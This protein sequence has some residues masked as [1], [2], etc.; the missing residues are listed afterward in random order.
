MLTGSVALSFSVSALRTRM[1][2]TGKWS[3]MA[4]L[5]MY[6]YSVLHSMA[7]ISLLLFI[8][9]RMGIMRRSLSTLYVH[10]HVILTAT[11]YW[12]QARASVG[13]AC[14]IIYGGYIRDRGT[15]MSIAHS[16]SVISLL[17]MHVYHEATLTATG[18]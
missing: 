10:V 17:D 14:S 5:C 18:R 13:S 3:I 6:F 15:D 9:P 11:R 12:S 16:F 2:S 4:S 7:V 8:I 1:D